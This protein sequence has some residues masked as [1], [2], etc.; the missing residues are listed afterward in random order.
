MKGR[1]MDKDR[2]RNRILMVGVALMLL[3]LFS[4][5]ATLDESDPNALPETE[6]VME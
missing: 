5:V 3:A 4:Y 2:R 6:Q 1:E